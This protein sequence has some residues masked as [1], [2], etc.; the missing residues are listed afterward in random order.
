MD[1]IDRRRLFT[2]LGAGVC[3]TGLGATV[4]GGWSARSLFGG[5]DERLEFGPLEPLVD[6]MQSCELDA[7]LPKLVGTW[8]TGTSLETLVAA[9]L[10][11]N[12][13]ALGGEDYEGYH[14][15]MAMAPAFDL[16]QGLPEGQRP[17]P[18]LKVLYRSAARIRKVGAQDHD[19]LARIEPAAGAIDLREMTYRDVSRAERLLIG[20]T[21]EGARSDLD[22][23]VRDDIN[24]H[25][26]VLAWRAWDGQ[27]FTG[28]AHAET[29][30]R[31]VLRFCAYE[32]RLR[33]SRSQDLPDVRTAVPEIFEEHGLGS[34]TEGQR[35]L[36]DA[37]L[38]RLAGQVFA[39]SRSQAAGAVAEAL[40]A[41]FDPEQ[42][43]ETIS[44]AACQLLL[45]DPGRSRSQGALPRGSVHGASTGVHASD[46]AN[47][48]RHLAR[49]ARGAERLE[50]LLAAAYHTAGQSHLVGDAPFAPAARPAEEDPARILSDLDAA[51]NSGDQRAA[52]GL[53]SA[54]LNA[55]G[56]PQPLFEKMRRI[57]IE[58]DGALHAEKFFH[59]CLEGWRSTRATRRD[60]HLI[61]LAR[62]CASEVGVRA[63]GLAQAH[64]LLG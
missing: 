53:S 19:A 7:L 48:W 64:D 41:G 10:L 8:R 63:P 13:R 49:Q 11:A 28:P 39:S 24:V 58:V 62:V 45:N 17:L 47:A 23:L 50:T 21:V 32:D 56:D 44:L 27:R 38:D 6:L 16:A 9:G 15:M 54:Y 35:P 4:F 60:R 46:A 42:V 37:E 29:L 51:W 12:A 14:A 55:G 18:V 25:R 2:R 30:L 52:Q 22:H 36:E 3:L 40:A 59:T 26:V 20:R 61:A 57:T 5:G 1:R 31:Q 33:K 34:V 43:G